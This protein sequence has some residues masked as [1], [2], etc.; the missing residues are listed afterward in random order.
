MTT[1]ILVTVLT[2]FSGEVREWC[3]YDLLE[4]RPPAGQYV[5]VKVGDVVIDVCVAGKTIEESE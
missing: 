5:E 3:S 4:Q 2:C 1:L